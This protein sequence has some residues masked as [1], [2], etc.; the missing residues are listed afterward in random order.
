[1]NIF[2]ITISEFGITYYII[3]NIVN[4]ITD[5]QIVGGY[6]SEANQN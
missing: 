3:N 1:M 4:Y 6:I 2:Q 5:S